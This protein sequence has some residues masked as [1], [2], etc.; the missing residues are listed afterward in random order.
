M[1]AS[2]KTETA[3]MPS[4]T[5]RAAAG[6][7]LRARVSRES[8]ADFEPAA[9]RDPSAV[10]AEV[11]AGRIA[12]LIPIRYERML[13]SP[14]T[15]LRGAAAVMAADLAA[16]PTIGIPVQACG[17][18]HL[19]NFGAFGT[20]EGRILFD[21]NDFDETLPGIDFTVD[22]KRL[23]ASVAVAAL[24][25][26]YSDKK[27][28]SFAAATAQA[29]RDFM[30][31]LADLS[32]LAIW[33]SRMD[34]A[35][36]TERIDDRKLRRTLLKTIVKA[37]KT[38][39][40]D[41]NFPHLAR[42][43]A[44]VCRIEDR[45]P[46]IYHLDADGGGHHAVDARA[47]LAIY[48]ATLPPDRH[49][50][51]TRFRL[52]DVAFKVVGVGSVGT[53]CAIGLY[54]SGDDEPLFLQIKEAQSSVLERFRPAGKHRRHQGHRVVE[55]Q[56]VMQ[57]ASDAFLGWAED[58]KSGRHFYVRQLKNRRLGSVGEVM[59]GNA[60]LEYAALCGRTLARAHARSG[61]PA[62]ISGYIGKSGVF[63]DAL[64]SFSLSYARQTAADHA[65]VARDRA[66]RKRR[67]A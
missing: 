66:G 6:K 45:P 42:T 29:Y 49:V 52:E 13:V 46:L 64:A 65:V 19:M 24:D 39:S 55:G 16:Q 8:H 18:C 28:R 4:R 32:P 7:A 21:I 27:A 36:E 22:L 67:R 25:A 38:L 51:L 10:L 1:P 35:R 62:V 31:E 53:F 14:F 57:A 59:E 33:H 41:D 60:L 30:R 5:D 9:G 63:E 37:K 44:G 26:G 23:V 56:R 61:D 12:A 40:L 11:D 20:P 2:T 17:D 34:L 47:A 54:M 48:Q 3:P 15:F 50:L 43:K 58:R